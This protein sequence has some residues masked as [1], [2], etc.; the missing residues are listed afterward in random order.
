MPIN[1]APDQTN[2]E[3][4]QDTHIWQEIS[5]SRP[6]GEFK[7]TTDFGPPVSSVAFPQLE[8]AT[9]RSRWVS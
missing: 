6:A 1:A 9:R 5:P 3:Y 8:E 2:M 4:S 7:K